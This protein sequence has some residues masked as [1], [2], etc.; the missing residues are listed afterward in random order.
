MHAHVV[1]S[2]PW[3]PPQERGVQ[4]WLWGGSSH[5]SGGGNPRTRRLAV[6]PTNPSPPPPPPLHTT[7]QATTTGFHASS[8]Y[9]SLEQTSDIKILPAAE[10]M[11]VNDLIV[12]GEGPHDHVPEPLQTFES[13]GY[14]PDL[15]GEV[16]GAQ[17]GG[18]RGSAHTSARRASD[19]HASSSSLTPPPHCTNPNQPT[20]QERRLQGAD[21]DP[22]AGVAHRAR[23]A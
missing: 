3:Q 16:R 4:F 9:G 21:R 13:A 19:Q 22:G 6:S 14:P 17:D 11:R 15:L 1:A 5:S 10:Y 7:Q 12:H 8:S 18:R 2:K 20:D 23:G